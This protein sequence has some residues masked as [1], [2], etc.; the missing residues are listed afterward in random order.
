MALKFC[1]LATVL[2]SHCVICACVN[3]CCVAKLL[4]IGEP[5]IIIILG[6]QSLCVVVCASSAVEWG[7]ELPHLLSSPGR[8]VS[9]WTRQAPS[10]Q[11]PQE[12]RLP[13]QGDCRSGDQ[14]V[15]PLIMTT[16]TCNT[17]VCFPYAPNDLPVHTCIYIHVLVTFH[18]FNIQSYNT[19]LETFATEHC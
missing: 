14:L 12:V 4:F 8:D 18:L 3:T 5:L 15:L 19:N 9:Q 17:A 13:H 6:S 16:S 2:C 7:E 11:Q 1:N 10:C